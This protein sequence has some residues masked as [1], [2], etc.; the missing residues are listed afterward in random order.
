[1]LAAF[2]YGPTEPQL[3][4]H[5]FGG[6]PKWANSDLYDL[7][8][9]VSDADA[10][11]LRKLGP[12]QRAQMLSLMLR[13]L[14][15]DRFRLAVHKESR[16]VLSYDLVIA[17]GGVKLKE[18]KSDDPDLPN[19]ALRITN[20]R[21]T[22]AGISMA[23]LAGALTGQVKH[24]VADGTGLKG[25]YD[26]SLNWQP[27]EEFGQGAVTENMQPALPPSNAPSGPAIFTALQEQLGLRLQSKEGNAN[28]IIVDHVARPSEN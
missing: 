9:K 6:A 2:A 21:I 7:I 11:G 15:T 5:G 20:G 24:P 18:G 17:K 12:D 13:T 22:G 14:L 1:M 27:E 8:A 23:R 28:I 3:G 4:D 10:E 26:F 16:E 19:G 25:T